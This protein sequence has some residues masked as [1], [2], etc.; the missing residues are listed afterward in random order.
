[1]NALATIALFKQALAVTSERIRDK[2]AASKRKGPWVGG[3]APLGCHEDPM[4][5]TTSKY[6]SGSKGTRAKSKHLKTARSTPRKPTSP[7]TRRPR[8]AASASIAAI[9]KE[10]SGTKQARVIA[11]LCAPEGA[12]LDAMMQATGWQ[13]HSVRGFLAG[14]ARKKLGLDLHSEAGDNGRVYRIEDRAPS[15][16]TGPKAGRAA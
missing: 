3:I 16:A 10:R 11:M 9:G 8:T 15:S 6:P 4:T 12:T 7:Q 13:Q 5:K 14:V 1:M 2:I